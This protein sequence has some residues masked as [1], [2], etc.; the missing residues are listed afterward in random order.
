VLLCGRL[1]TSGRVHFAVASLLTVLLSRAFQNHGMHELNKMDGSPIAVDGQHI[2]ASFAI[3]PSCCQRTELGKRLI[4]RFGDCW[5]HRSLSRQ[6]GLL[7]LDD[8]E[9]ST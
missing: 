4:R 2:A 5:Q 8:R 6:A 3:S 1:R 9:G 7:Y